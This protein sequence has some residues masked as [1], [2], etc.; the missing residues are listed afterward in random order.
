MQNLE[1]FRWYLQK[2]KKGVRGN[3]WRLSHI[4]NNLV[5]S[6]KGKQI[7]LPLAATVSATV[8]N[9]VEDKSKYTIAV[10]KRYR[11]WNARITWKNRCWP[12]SRC[13]YIEANSPFPRHCPSPLELTALF[14]VVRSSWIT[15]VR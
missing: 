10:D 15:L 9:K 3:L 13:R 5:V 14:G 2:E 6:D 1:Y 4:S 8:Y 7:L 12:I 11:D